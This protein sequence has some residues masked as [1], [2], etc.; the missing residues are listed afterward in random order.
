MKNIT[1]EDEPL[2]AWNGM[3]SRK[4]PRKMVNTS[5]A[6]EKGEEFDRGEEEIAGSPTCRRGSLRN[7][8]MMDIAK[9][10]LPARESRGVRRSQGARIRSCSVSG[11]TGRHWPLASVSAPERH[12]E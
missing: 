7:L 11:V 6:K 1:V 9:S 10:I 2:E 4:S 5:Q 12:A 8:R 3:E